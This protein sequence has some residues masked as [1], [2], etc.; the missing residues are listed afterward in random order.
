MTHDKL[1]VKL[2]KLSEIKLS[3]LIQILMLMVVLVQLYFMNKAFLADH[4]RRKKQATIEYVN[5]IRKIYRDLTNNLTRKFS[6]QSINLDS[7]DDETS[8]EIQELLS[9]LEHLSVGINTGVY[10]YK[11]IKRMTGTFFVNRYHQLLP[12]IKDAQK[13]QPTRFIEFERLCKKIEKDKQSIY[14][15]NEGKIEHS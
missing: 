15:N 4:E 14:T 3:D 6:N 11:I 1:P 12:Y 7:I 8:E 10:S 9:T 13:I 2:L 5:T